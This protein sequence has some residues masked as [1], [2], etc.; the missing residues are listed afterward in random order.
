MKKQLLLFA[1]IL[2]PLVTSAHDIEV[3]NADGVTIYYNYI[4]NGTELEVTFR[5]SK[6]DSYSNEYQGNVAIPEEVTYMNRTRKVTSIGSNAFYDCKGLT[7]VIIPNSVTSIGNGAFAGCYGLTSV[8]IPNSVTSIGDSAFS[9]CYGLTSVTIPNS[10]TSIGNYAF[11]GCKGLTSV[12]IPNS[13]TSI[14][15]YAF[16]YC[17]GL[18]S[19]TIPNSVT[20]IGYCAFYYMKLSVVVSLIENPFPIKS[21]FSFDWI[22]KDVTL[23]VPVGT[24]EKYQAT[25]GWK[26]FQNI[27]EGT[28]TGIKVIENTKNKNATVYDLNGVRLPAPKKG[29]NIINGQKVVVK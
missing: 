7:S 29:I 1:M 17:S 10:V 27:V 2:L 18:T 9:G 8:T 11:Y 28:P 5:G 14:G 26:E 15:N 13:V 6:S 23:Y 21:V 25:D 24:K 20:S 22:A 16:L 4:N 19:V 12:T 3:K